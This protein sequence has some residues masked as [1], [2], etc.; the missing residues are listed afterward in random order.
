VLTVLGVVAVAGAAVLGAA[1][2]VS[3]WLG[4][5]VEAVIC[6]QCLAVKSLRQESMKVVASLDAGDLPRA[7]MEVAMIIG[8]DTVRL[9]EAGVARA[10]VETVAE[11]TSDG[12]VAPLAA[13]LVAGGWGGLLYKAVNTMD[14]MV[15]YHNDRYED[16]GRTAARLDD[17]VNWLP[18]RLAAL[19]MV[20]AA[21]LTRRDAL[22]ACR[23][24]RRDHARNPSPNAGQTEAACAG[25]LGVRLG[26]PAT[27][28]GVAHDKPL[29]NAEG[30]TATAGDIAASNRLAGAA[31]WLALGFVLVVRL[32]VWGVV[33]HAAR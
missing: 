16:F 14:S 33:A 28:G 24:W 7:R 18:S 30:R 2:A 31:A 26:G 3:V 25:A 32:G 12:V 5:A 6:F 27:Y 22:Q 8:R 13:M 10:A 15:G 20:I 1:Y 21:R 23:I 19:L 9:D 29:I 11:S 17:F 4:C